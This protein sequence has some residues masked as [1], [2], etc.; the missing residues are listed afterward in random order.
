MLRYDATDQH[1]CRSTSTFG[2]ETRGKMEKVAF[3]ISPFSYNGATRLGLFCPLSIDVIT[4]AANG[5][6]G[7]RLIM[8]TI[9]CWRNR[10]VII[11]SFLKKKSAGISDLDCGVVGLNR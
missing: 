7:E 11:L 3:W 5:V 2:W 4:A 1:A 10:I 6:E 9:A 8:E